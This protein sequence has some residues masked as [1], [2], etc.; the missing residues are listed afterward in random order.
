MSHRPL[1]NNRCIE[2]KEKRNCRG[3]NCGGNNSRIFFKTV[4]LAFPD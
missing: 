1:L 2:R 4:E 3:R